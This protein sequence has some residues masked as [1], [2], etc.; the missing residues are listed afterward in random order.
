MLVDL[1]TAADQPDPIDTGGND[2]HGAQNVQSELW[3]VFHDDLAGR[4]E[5]AASPMILSDKPVLLPLERFVCRGV[6]EYF[7]RDT[8]H[9]IKQKYPGK[10]FPGIRS[11]SPVAVEI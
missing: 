2:D 4:A 1:L 5:Q 11:L 8:K 7:D 10:Q 9:S 3:E 6:G